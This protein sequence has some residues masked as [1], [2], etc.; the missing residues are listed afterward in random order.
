MPP[1]A[2]NNHTLDHLLRDTGEIAQ[3]LR[4]AGEIIEIL[5][6][7]KTWEHFTDDQKR[8]ASAVV[9]ALHYGNMKAIREL[10]EEYALR[11]LLKKPD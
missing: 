4:D 1:H 9:T 3:R 11:R 6:N 8:L 7:E 2:H 10:R 5:N